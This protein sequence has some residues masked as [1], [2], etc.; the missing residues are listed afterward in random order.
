MADAL[1][2][3]MKNNPV[4]Y[5]SNLYNEGFTTSEALICIYLPINL[6]TN[7]SKGQNFGKVAN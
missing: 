1:A 3:A 5:S 2:K 4:L 7:F 6:P